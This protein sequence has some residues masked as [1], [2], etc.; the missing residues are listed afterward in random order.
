MEFDLARLR[1]VKDDAGFVAV[2]E[3][4]CNESITPDYWTV[5]LPG[6]LATSSPRSP[7]LF[8]Y[9]AALN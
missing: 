1:D 4:V 8:A 2:I 3:Q 5:V 9:H 6:E 7:S